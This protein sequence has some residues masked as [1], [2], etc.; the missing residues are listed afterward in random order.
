MFRPLLLVLAVFAALLSVIS[1][2][3]CGGQAPTQ[4][5]A[6]A[7]SRVKDTTNPV[8][9]VLPAVL[10]VIAENLTMR[11]MGTGIIVD[12]SGVILTCQHVV[13][14]AGSGDVTAVLNDGSKH[15]GSV[16]KADKAKDLAVIILNSK[17]TSLPVASLGNSDESDNLQLGNDIYIVGYPLS[18]VLTGPATITK[19]IISAFRTLDSV[20]VIQTD[21]AVNPG[22][23]G[24]PMINSDG[25]VIGIV[26]S[27][28]EAGINFAIAINEADEII[29]AAE[30]PPIITPPVTPPTPTVTP[31]T[32]TVTPS[33]P[34]VIPPTPPVTQPT[35]TVTRL[36]LLIQP[37]PLI[38]S[39]LPG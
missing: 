4:K 30:M 11:S 36:L 16:V 27:G 5:A 17:E 3:S 1:A 8:N 19:G 37:T 7:I 2:G 12:R 24:G 34:P 29:R 6:G 10:E 38:H 32:P 14:I 35:P 15:A 9:K 20:H 23:S 28:N 13:G 31:S 18:N 26:E 22:N 39:L 21:A 33:T 25:E